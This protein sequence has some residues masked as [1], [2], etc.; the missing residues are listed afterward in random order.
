MLWAIIFITMERK[1][2]DKLNF[3]VALNNSDYF[4]PHPGVSP[5][6][7]PQNLNES[8]FFKYASSIIQVVAEDKLD[9][10][11]AGNSSQHP[12]NAIFEISE[13]KEFEGGGSGG[14][15]SSCWE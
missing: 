5:A 8:L 7:H 2:P 3:A 4:D 14:A 6:P 12:R 13:V 1:K 11:Y 9:S 10:S 15:A